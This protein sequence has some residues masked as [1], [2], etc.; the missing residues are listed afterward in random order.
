MKRCKITAFLIIAAT[1][2]FFRTTAC[3]DLKTLIEVGKSQ[4]TI[5]KALKNET[6][7]YNRVKE[8]IASEKLK[9]GMPAEKLRKKYGEPVIDIFDKKK[10]AYKWLYMPATSTHFEGEKIYL[11]IDEEGEL[12]GWQVL[13]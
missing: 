5:G 6:R 8:A 10:S 9:E 11:F 1:A 3:A 12:V 2:L 4:A 13:E 7:N